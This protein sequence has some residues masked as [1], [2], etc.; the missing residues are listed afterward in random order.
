MGGGGDCPELALAGIKNSIDEA[1]QNSLAFVFTDASAKDYDR[2]DEVVGIIQRKQILVNFLT[3]GNCDDPSGPGFQVYEK[4]S[5][6]SGGQVFAMTR[7]NVRDVLMATSIAMESDFVS[8]KSFDYDLDGETSITLPVDKSFTRMTVS[9]TGSSATL[10]IRDSKGNEI[11]SADSFSATNIQIVTFDVDDNL[12]TIQVSARSAFAIRIGGISELNFEFGF[13]LNEPATQDDTFVQPLV[14]E[15]NIL[16]IFI[17]DPA[18]VK[19]LTKV[20]LVP[21]ST[22]DTF[23]DL[24]IP[25]KRTKSGFFTSDPF[26]IP[27]KMFRIQIVGFDAAG[28][29]IERLISTGIDSIAASK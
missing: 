8:L 18:M 5:R 23:D 9:V 10:K 21:A 27:N 11:T 1:L 16:S 20:T 25:L 2:Y 28:N 15:M 12:Y 19:C 14:G 22:L 6:T 13:S 24:E 29:S 3:T 26:W 4:L 17:S 7:D